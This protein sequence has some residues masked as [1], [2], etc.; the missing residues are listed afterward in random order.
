MLWANE[1][2]HLPAPHD[3]VSE[4]V[5]DGD[6]VVVDYSD[7]VALSATY[8]IDEIELGDPIPYHR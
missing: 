4:Y 2:G 7:R 5:S 6:T 1:D 8:G 3:L